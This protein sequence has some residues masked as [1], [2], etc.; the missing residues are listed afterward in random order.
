MGGGGGFEL[1]AAGGI[2]VMGMALD[3]GF[4]AASICE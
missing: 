2:R 4:S 3:G 1:I